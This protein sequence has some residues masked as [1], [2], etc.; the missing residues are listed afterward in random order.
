MTSS[1]PAALAT[2]HFRSWLDK[3]SDDELA[4]ILRN[5][6]DTTVPL[7]PGIAP[8]ATRLLLRSSIARA[9][10]QTCTAADLA[11][12]EGIVKLGGDL[13]PVAAERPEG[14]LERALAFEIDGMYMVPPE[15]VAAYPT[16]FSVLDQR[17]VDPQTLEELPKEQRRILETLKD[18][19]VGTT[20]DAAL[21]ADPQRPVPQLIAAGLIDRVDSTTVRLPRATRLA[22]QG[23]TPAPIPVEP[24]DRRGTPAP[25]QTADEAG[26]AA[27]IEA[28]R[29]MERLVDILGRKP[30]ELLKDK[31][32]GVRPLAQLGTLLDTPHA[33][34]LIAL[35]VAA[36]LLG[37]GEPKGGPE[38]NFL[39]PTQATDEWL[40]APLA[41]RWELLLDAWEHSTW[42]AWESGR[43]LDSETQ[44]DALPRTRTAI[45]D[46]FR[47]CHAPLDREEFWEEL[48]FSRPIFAT[49]VARETVE[50]LLDE[51]EWL[52][53][54]AR[55]QLT[56]TRPVPEPVEHFIVQADHT[57]LVPGPLAAEPR[58][59]M[60]LIADLE[61]PGLA[62]VFRVTAASIRRGMDAGLTAAEMRA[63]LSERGIGELPQTV[64]FLIDDVARSHG[65]LRG[66]PAMS[67]IRSE[68]PALLAQAAGAVPHLRVLAPTVAIS[69][70]PL[71]E[72]LAA[73]RDAGFAP[74]AEDSDGATITARPEPLLLPTPRAAS[75][76]AP[77]DVD[78][79]VAAVRAHS[80]S[81]ADA[82]SP[83]P[84]PD[85][86]V[87]ESAAR[88]ARPI[89]LGWADKEGRPRTATVTP[90][91]VA[92]GQIDALDAHGRPVRFP[93]HR[94]TSVSEA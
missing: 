93:V 86:S 83:A 68:D 45:I 40:A 15:V 48:R 2:A 90:L 26:A 29:L 74:A 82:P 5:R 23:R 33:A 28:V 91:S 61:S 66:G 20:R 35:G 56:Q 71:A 43:A 12:L 85:L 10:S 50:Q 31:T 73:L 41:A 4:T 42:A 46:V 17:P 25:D 78:R 39:A 63:F 92:G 57:I 16:G 9:L 77:L 52:G 80:S 89:V 75:R 32:V 3:R 44:H 21:D 27:G 84:G 79:A 24:S 88:G 58:T 8:L 6:P 36:R 94:I 65:T 11:A 7:P 22:L 60:E 70:R 76:P 34:R 55:G 1:S 49:L 51:A 37:R 19:G 30:V 62:S 59:T 87:V 14:L 67:Y 81:L 18:T 13:E 64:G 38:G 72:V 54:I 47:N 69:S 53:V